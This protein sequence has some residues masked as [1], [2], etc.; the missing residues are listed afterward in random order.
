MPEP[1][2]ITL[3]AQPD[4]TWKIDGMNLYGDTKPVEA[5]AAVIRLKPDGKWQIDVKHPK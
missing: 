1:L 5:R 3:T 2:K 4:G